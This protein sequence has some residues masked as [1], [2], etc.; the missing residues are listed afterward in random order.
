M[1][2][3][4][5]TSDRIRVIGLD[6]KAG[7]LVEQAMQVLCDGGFLP[8]KS[9]NNMYKLAFEVTDE[10]LGWYHFHHH[11][12]HVSLNNVAG[13]SS[14]SMLATKCLT[15]DCTPAV[16]D[17]GVLEHVQVPGHARVINP[18]AG[19]EKVRVLHLDL[20]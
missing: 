16:H 7:A 8:T 1:L 15:P 12:F 19:L 5:L 2:G 11:H 14:N 9:C 17:L 6:G 13:S 3:A 10:G 18:K 4:L 20:E